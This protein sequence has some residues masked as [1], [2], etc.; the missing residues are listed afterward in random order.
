MSAGKTTGEAHPHD[1]AP[2]RGEDIGIWDLVAAVWRWKWLIALIA[3]LAGAA[4]YGVSYLMT[5]E[6]R[7]SVVLSPAT[8]NTERS[9]LA[10]LMGQIGGLGGLAGLGLPES[11]RDEEAFATLK[12]RSFTE[13]FIENHGLMPVLFPAAWDESSESWRNEPG[14]VQPSIRDGFAVMD[15]SVRTL[16]RDRETGL[17]TLHMDWSDPEQAASWANDMVSDVNDRL[18]TQTVRE[19]QR[20]ID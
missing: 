5:P 15:G 14:S 13:S 12:S 18:R 1:L 20:S 17:V 7:A 10:G 9:R 19:A 8:G 6:Y 4:A 3:L 16:V 2:A 11:E